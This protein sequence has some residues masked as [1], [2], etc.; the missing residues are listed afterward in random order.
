MLECKPLT[1]LME[2]NAK[3]CA[4]EGK[5]LDDTR[6]YRRLVGNLIYLTLTRSDIIYAVRVASRH[7]QN[8]KKTRLESVKKI[9]RYVKGTLDYDILYQKD[10]VCQV[11]SY[12]DAD[13]AGDYDTRRSTVGYVFSLGSGAM[14]WCSK[15]QPT[16]FL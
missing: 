11:I 2:S 15:K 3:L 1:T 8:P 9:L 14:S 6:M 16:M 4:G 7:M 13:Y 12:C 10:G 5:D